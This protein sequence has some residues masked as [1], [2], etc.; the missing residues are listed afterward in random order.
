MRAWA[1]GMRSRKG[2]VLAL[3]WLLILVVAAWG[4]TT[5]AWR[6]APSV[7]WTLVVLSAAGN[8]ALMRMPLSYFHQPTHWMHLFIADT[9]FVGA[10]IYCVVG[11][12]SEFYLPYF[13]IVLIAALTRSLARALAVAV[14]ISV[15]YM[16]L[17]WREQ[18]A[19]RFLDTS[20][21]IRLPFFLI[22]ALFTSYLA[23]AARLQQEAQDASRALTDQVRSLQQLAAGVAHEV[24]NPLTAISN[25]LQVLIN[26]LPDGGEDRT[27]AGEA[28]AQVSRVTRIVQKTLEVAR[29]VKL[30]ESWLDVNECLETVLHDAAAAHRADGI[31]IRKRMAPQ[32]L[33]M[34]GDA[35]LLG[36]VFSNLVRNALEAM[37]KGGVLEVTTGTGS[38][39]GIERVTVRI[40][41]N[42]PGIPAHQIER[43]Y[44][45]FYTTKERGTGLGL[46]L[47]RKYV[48]A[49]GGGLSVGGRP[50]GGTEAVVTLPVAGPR[51]SPPEEESAHGP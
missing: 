11:F 27:I 44:Q 18:S 49:H 34:W 17:V 12:D 28:L 3:Q 43:L 13:L 4:A 1:A 46:W 26:R 37:R 10:A 21:L 50:G 31:E 33:A 29:P 15:I 35:L 39:A 6:A 32:A 19:E 41:D 20:Y 48:R 47:A 14:S 51:P 23:N 7:F 5:G 38:R 24:R 36:Q 42:G 22:I 30:Q 25:S 40:S 8:L 2:Y 45:P 16:Y 9:M